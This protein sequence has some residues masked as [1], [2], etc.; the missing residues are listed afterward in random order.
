MEEALKLVLRDGTDGYE[1]FAKATP[2]Q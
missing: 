1:V 2:A